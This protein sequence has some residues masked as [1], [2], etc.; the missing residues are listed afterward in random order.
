MLSDAG[1]VITTLALD[2]A[3][4]GDQFVVLPT[5]NNTTEIFMLAASSGT[6][7]TG[8]GLGDSFS[9]IGSDIGAW[10]QAGNWVD[11]TS[12]ANPATIAPGAVD[13]ITV[14][15]NTS[16]YAVLDGSGAAASASI[17]NAALAGD[18]SIG[19]LTTGGQ[20]DLLAGGT[21]TAA[22][23][24]ADG[25]LDI[26]GPGTS[27][28]AGAMTV[29]AGLTLSGGAEVQVAQLTLAGSVLIVSVD[30]LSTLEVGTLGHAAPGALSIDPGATLTYQGAS[31]EGSVIDNGVIL[32][33]Y[34]LSLSGGTLS[35]TGLV[36]I[37][38]GSNVTIYDSLSGQL[39]FQLPAMRN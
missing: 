32:A 33:E 27:L 28:Q 25:F 30:T 38:T 6:L 29:G 7:S 4:A 26:S 9:W 23:I 22:Q 19:T 39:T 11:N 3:Y 37:G 34:G 1:S 35:G 17:G 36:S 21:L 12:G 13:H 2:G 16:A 15:G 10:D 20:L 5:N 31:I 24:I 18:F 14:Y 8:T